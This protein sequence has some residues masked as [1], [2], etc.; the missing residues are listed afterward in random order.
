MWEYLQHNDR[1]AGE[2]LLADLLSDHPDDPDLRQTE[3]ALEAPHG[4][5]SPVWRIPPAAIG[6]VDRPALMGRIAQVL[7]T[8]PVAL[9]G[10]GGAG[11]TRLAVEYAHRHASAYGAVWW[12]DA[13]PGQSIG[14]QLAELAVAVNACGPASSVPDAVAALHR[15]LGE[16]SP[17]SHL[18]IF[19]N[20]QTPQDLAPWLPGTGA[21]VLITSRN[22]LWIETA[23]A[24]TVGVFPREQSHELL[25]RWLPSLDPATAD[26]VAAALGDLPLALAQ[27][28]YV[29]AA[30]GMPADVY[31]D[32]LDRRTLEVLD[33]PGPAGYPATLAA[34][35]LATT[36]QLAES[37]PAAADLLRQCALLAAETVP[38]ALLRQ[39]AGEA[40]V[41]PALEHLGR[42]GIA[43]IDQRGLLLHRLTQLVIRDWL[44]AADR[45]ALRDRVV[46]AVV[47]CAPG[48]LAEMPATWSRWAELR[49]HV[50]ALE[51]AEASEP[52][53]REI[54]LRLVRYQLIRGES[55]AAALAQPSGCTPCGATG[56]DRSIRRPLLRR[57][58]MPARWAMSA[59]STRPGRC[60]GIP[61]RRSGGCWA[62]ATR[63]CC[64]PL[65]RSR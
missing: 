31:L 64:A 29:M 57:G 13:G 60:C 1:A 27:G 32:A 52:D 24:V 61:L 10:I 20:A 7:P 17:R 16:A 59:A 51:P 19:D 18:V 44:T 47:A 53:L 49:P 50:L 9:C 22:P 8:G 3:R 4:L 15:R 63:P 6:N 26:R 40:S 62:T 42:F 38:T 25:R 33:R 21:D 39:A 30:Q 58:A 43:R 14:G 65:P 28:A 11:K 35:I 54:A 34:T 12:V 2:R 5:R 46:S 55:A 36:Q 41:W 56:S 23:V 48:D 45:A 37:A